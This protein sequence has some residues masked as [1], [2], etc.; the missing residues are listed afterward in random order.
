[1]ASDFEKPDKV[2]TLFPEEVPQK[3]W[4]L[5][6]GALFGVGP[7]AVKRLNRCGIYTIGDL[8]QTERRVIVGIFGARGDTLWNYANGREADPVTKQATRDNTYGNSVTLPR[9]LAKPEEAD[10]TLLAL[11]DSVGR[12]LRS[13]GKTARVVTVQLVDNAFRRTSH[14]R[15]LPDP[16][17]S[18]DRLYEVTLQLMRQMW[19]ARPV[20]LVGISAEKTGTDNFEQLDLFT[21]TTR[22]QKQEAL[23]RTADALRRKFGGAVVTR[24]KL[25][26]PETRAPAAPL[27]R[28]GAGQ[29][30]K[31]N[32]A[33]QGPRRHPSARPFAVPSTKSGRSAQ[34]A[35]APHKAESNEWKSHSI[36]GILFCAALE[37]TPQKLVNLH[38]NKAKTME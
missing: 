19:P 27:R 22:R 12:R 14:Q 5:P 33:A 34:G 13:D 23:D 25:L 24:A 15:T 1:M 2:H 30:K 26:T 31:R 36:D 6:V 21:D 7:S 16:T 28:Q 3:M 8:A 37:R 11:C 32:K 10:A 18:T 4:P 29:G 9:D 17:N 20:R 38:K 35:L